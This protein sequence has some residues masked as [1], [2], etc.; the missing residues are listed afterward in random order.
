MCAKITATVLPV[1]SSHRPL[2]KPNIRRFHQALTRLSINPAP[3][4]ARLGI[5]PEIMKDDDNGLSMRKYLELLELAAEQS[6][7]RFL[8]IEIALENRNTD[9][10]I[11][12]YILRSAL[13]FEKALD[14]LQRYV[15]LV[16]PGSSISLMQEGTDC[17]LTYKLPGFP[18]ISCRQDVE[19]TMA[20][21]VLMI[22]AVSHD[23]TW[24]PKKI[25]FEH[26]APSGED[27]DNFPLA[28]EL[29]FDHSYSGVFFSQDLLQYPNDNYDP[30]LLAL[31]ESQVLQTAED[32]LNSD[33]LLDRVRLLI[34][35]NLGHL[36]IT[37]NTIAKELGMSR[38]TLYRRLAEQGS[39]VNTLRECV[40]LDLAR[41]GLAGTSIPITQ[42]AQN[43][44][45]SDSSAFDRAFKRLDGHT[46]LQ[47]RKLHKQG[48]K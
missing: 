5:D 1:S 16:S 27:L 6:G 26:P 2:Q 39:S 34:S 40:V 20:Q 13:N 44:G 45:Y 14:L 48:E 18:P 21:F 9:L 11:L 12:G 15:R 28:G 46:P 37:A 25:F 24:Q 42:L 30:Q 17:A 3:I 22:Q 35:S 7:R 8:G 10:G 32:L 31:L 43:L 41:E 33:T 4:Y 23:A 47:Y 38:R 29:I 36:E 19:A